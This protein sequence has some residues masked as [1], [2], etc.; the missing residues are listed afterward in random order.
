[1]STAHKLPDQPSVVPASGSSFTPRAVAIG[2]FATAILA[3]GTQL[4]E[5]WIHGTQVSQSTP[6]INSFFVWIV[7]VVLLNTILRGI[8][9]TLALSRGELLLI[10]AML[11]VSGGVAGIGLTH[12]IPGL[13]TA[14]IYYGT[15]DQPWTALVEGLTPKSE[16]FAPHNE[17]VIRYLYEGMPPTWTVPWEPWVKPLTSWTFFGLLLAWCTV[18]IC[19]LLR[20]QWVEN[21]KLIF[22]LNYV[23]LAMTD[24]SGGEAP[25]A[26][27]PFF[28]N[29]LMWIGF[30]IPTILHLFNSL[31]Q[32]WP[33]IPEMRIRDVRID[34]GL[35]ARPWNAMRPLSVWFYP[36]AVGLSYL[37]SRD[38]SFSLWFFYFVG[39]AEAVLGSA[40]GLSGGG[41]GASL[42]GFPFMEEQSSGALLMLTLGSLWVARKHLAN[43]WKMATSG[44]IR[45]KSDLLTPAVAVWGLVVGLALIVVWWQLAGMSP[46]ASLLYFGLFFLY[47]IGLTRLVCEGGTVWIGTPLDPRQ[48]VRNA[49]GV[50]GLSPRDWTMMGYMRFLTMDWRCLMMPNVMSALKFVETD[51]LKPRGLISAM[52]LG[53]TTTTVISFITVIYMA[54]TTPGGGIGLSTWRYIG[55]PQEPFQITGQFLMNKGGPVPMKIAFMGIG[56]LMMGGLQAMR[57]RFLWWPLHPLGYPMAGTFAMRNMWFSTLIAWAIKSV[58]LRYGGIPTYEKTRPFFLGLI[59]GD[60]VNIG[61][62]LVIEAFTGVQDHFLY[63]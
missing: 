34:A 21:E 7:I 53:I 3:V 43:L 44:Q 52:M 45:T 11:I 22:P 5:L 30:A 41:G 6:P 16:W 8:R 46:K 63:P 58:I 13:I 61:L 27:H 24:A 35:S 49:L 39:K 56:A 37:L 50:S 4:A 55:V 29:R 28:R 48:V 2:I 54:Y 15:P 23:P 14:P 20:Q 26:F 62:W 25:S 47:A 42:A 51:E 36:M 17:Q 9:R 38:I 57:T 1:M 40:M 32:I 31:H 10:Y 33:N 12:F 59:L 60:L 19:V 18:C